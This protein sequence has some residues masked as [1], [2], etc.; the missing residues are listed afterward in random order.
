MRESKVRG[1]GERRLIK[2]VAILDSEGGLHKADFGGVGEEGITWET[3]SGKPERIVTAGEDGKIGRDILPES[4]VSKGENGKIDEGELPDA[5]VKKNAD[6]KIPN[7]A[8]PGMAVGE[9]PLTFGAKDAVA[10]K[11]DRKSDV[12]TGATMLRYNGYFRATRVFGMYFS[13]N[14]DLAEL[15]A[16]EDG[17]EAGDLIEVAPSGGLRLSRSA[18]CT[19][20]LGVVSEAPGHILGWG[21]KARRGEKVVPVAL[22]GRVPVKVTGTVRPGDYLA[23][24]SIPGVAYSANPGNVPKGSIIGMALEEYDGDGQGKVLALVLRM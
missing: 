8:I 11:F 15:Y 14:A 24:S 10:G 20:V 5:V 7:E 4:V 22:A 1:M 9:T 3:I 6:G 18:R 21:T 12:P 2:G 13:D 16:V 23:A 19:N 17:A